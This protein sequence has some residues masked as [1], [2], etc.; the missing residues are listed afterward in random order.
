MTSRYST[1]L[2]ILL[3]LLSLRVAQ[4]QTV[5]FDASSPQRG[6]AQNQTAVPPANPGLN[7]STVQGPGQVQRTS[8]GYD[9]QPS[10]PGNVQNPAPVNGTPETSPTSR[11]E[12]REQPLVP[13][14]RRRQSTDTAPSRGAARMN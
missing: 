9:A 8:S 1:M 7:Q 10:R 6:G 13:Q 11:P 14:R 3:G 5:P 4:A 12:V 2:Y